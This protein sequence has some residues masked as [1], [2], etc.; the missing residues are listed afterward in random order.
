M[1]SKR[2]VD[3]SSTKKSSSTQQAQEQAAQ[4][5]SAAS[6]GLTDLQRQVGNRAVQRLVAQRTGGEDAYT[7]DEGTAQRVKQERGG[8]HPLDKATQQEIGQTLGRDLGDVRVHTG[9]EADRLNRALDAQAFTTGRDVFFREGKYAPHTTEGK[10]LLAHELTHVVDQQEGVVEESGSGTTV[11]APD[12][13]HE[14]RADAVS[15]EVAGPQSAQSRTYTP[16]QGMQSPSVQRQSDPEEELDLKAVQRQEEP[17][18]ELDLKAVQRQEEP[19]EELELKAI[20][21]QEEPEEELELK[22]VQ[23]QEEPEEEL[24]L[25]SIQRQE[26]PEEELELKSV[27]RQEEP[28]EELELKSVQRQEEPEELE[29]KATGR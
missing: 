19:E 6:S 10:E 26:E 24:E 14:Q 20:Q 12:D 16:G 23:R 28:E 13:A 21:R 17:E 2:K 25:K 7:L 15:K 3:K 4:K 11:H 8:G 22:S 5:T 1:G 9:A 27:Q 29:T 18:E